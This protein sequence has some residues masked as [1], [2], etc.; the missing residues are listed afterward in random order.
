MTELAQFEEVGDGLLVRAPAKINLSLLVV[1]KQPDGYHEIETLMA[2]VDYYDEL[3]F[4]PGQTRGIAL[5]CEG[6]Y[7]APEGEENLVWRACRALLDVVKADT[8]VRVTLRKNVPAGSGLGSASS[9]AAAALMG[10]NRFANLGASPRQIYEIACG[11]GSDIAFFLG[12]PL[13]FCTGRGEKIEGIVNFFPFRAILALPDVSVSTKKVY[14][15]YRH[16]QALYDELRERIN[17]LLSKKRIAS[18]IEICANMLETSCFDLHPELLR[19]KQ[20]LEAEG[21]GPVMLSGS[22]SAMFCMIAGTD[23]DPRRCQSMLR[24]SFGCESV[25]V[26]NNRW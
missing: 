14:E 13:A 1:G 22:G 19:L 11:L 23:A 4:Q 8:G 12:G 7:W 9:D 26:N 16:N 18:I 6:R 25:V 17:G 2:K 21:V 10:L 3:F 24:D 15:N 20:A 5:T